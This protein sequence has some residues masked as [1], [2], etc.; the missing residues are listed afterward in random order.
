MAV[1]IRTTCIMSSSIIEH[2]CSTTLVL[3]SQNHIFHDSTGC[4]KQ[5]E[6]FAQSHVFILKC[7]LTQCVK[8]RD[9]FSKI[10]GA[11]SQSSL[12]DDSVT[13]PAWWHFGGSHCLDNMTVSAAAS[14]LGRRKIKGPPG[15]PMSPCPSGCPARKDPRGGPVPAE[16]S[17]L[18]LAD[19]RGPSE[20]RGLCFRYSFFEGSERAFCS[21]SQFRL[22]NKYHKL[23]NLH[24]NNSG[25]WNV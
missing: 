9:T 21:L 2:A 13:F 23:E 16:P 6:F 5:V 8:N 25:V 3:I 19:P 7:V 15:P 11:W 22:H 14:L 24:N 18:A 17:A 10:N 12:L 20:G 4:F 1:R